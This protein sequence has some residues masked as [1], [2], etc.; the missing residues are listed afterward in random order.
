MEF[1]SADRTRDAEYTSE[2]R[3]Y[4][5]QVGLYNRDLTKQKLENKEE[6]ENLQ[7]SAGT[8]AHT[9]AMKEAG[10]HASALNQGLS[11]ARNIQKVGQPIRAT[12]DIVK[13]TGEGAKLFKK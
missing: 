5:Q 1:G 11:T 8:D 10:Q 6:G 13:G 2:L 9:G 4:N 7:S 3:H 12:E